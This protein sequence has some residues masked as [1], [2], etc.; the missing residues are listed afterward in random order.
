VGNPER[1]ASFAFPAS[2]DARADARGCPGGIH[3]RSP[4]KQAEKFLNHAL[5]DY[6][7]RLRW[8]VRFTDAIDPSR[9]PEILLDHIL[10]TQALVRGQGP[11]RV[12]AGAGRVEHEIFDRLNSQLPSGQRLSDHKPVSCD[13]TIDT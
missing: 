11:V 5:F 8:S 12:E 10:F 4:Q 9:D 7:G 2:A 1:S 6:P 3:R 13:I